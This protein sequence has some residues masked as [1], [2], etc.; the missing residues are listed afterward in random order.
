MQCL[1]WGARGCSSHLIGPTADRPGGHDE[2][3]HAIGEWSVGPGSGLVRGIVKGE[4]GLDK[5]DRARG[6][7]RPA[8]HR[9]HNGSDGHPNAPWRGAK[10]PIGIKLTLQQGRALPQ[11]MPYMQGNEPTDEKA[12]RTKVCKNERNSIL[13]G[14]RPPT[15]YVHR[16]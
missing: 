3:K 15:K 6:T 2:R 9:G 12:P 16:T 7:A 8:M 14:S 10:G 13:P 11:V 5:K 4:G 1:S